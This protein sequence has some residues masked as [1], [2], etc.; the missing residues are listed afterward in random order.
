MGYIPGS[1][2]LAKVVLNRKEGEN[3]PNGIP[4]GP[5]GI[6]PSLSSHSYINA[7]REGNIQNAQEYPSGE[8]LPKSKEVTDTKGQ[9]GNEASFRQKI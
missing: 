9:N 3:I 4:R 8:K 2:R 5:S 7:G 6:A 1:R